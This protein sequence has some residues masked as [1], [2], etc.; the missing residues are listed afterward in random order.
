MSYGTDSTMK[1][2]YL[3][4]IYQ[5]NNQVC[6]QMQLRNVDKGSSTLECFSACFTEMPVSNNVDYKNSLLICCEKKKGESQHRLKVIEIG[7]P[8]PDT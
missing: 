7:Q 3:I 2:C 1:W 4:V 8:A 5:E 6:C